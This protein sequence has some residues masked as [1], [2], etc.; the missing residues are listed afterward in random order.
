[1][2][3]LTHV[4]AVARA[5]AIRVLDYRVALDLREQPEHFASSTQVRFSARHAG[6]TWIDVRPHAVHAARLDD[7]ELDVAT[8]F[9]ASA[10]RLTL[11]AG[12]G[13]HELVVESLMAYSSD[14]EGLHRHVD[15]ADGRVYLYAMSFL[16]AA[17]R[18]FACF[19]QPDLKAPV[20]L[21]VRCPADWRVA[22]NGPATEVA[23]GHWQTAATG[24]LATYFTTVIAGPYHSVRDVHDGTELVLHVRQSLA[25]HLDRQADDLLAHTRHC[26]DELNGL[27]G[28][29]YPWGEYHQAFVPDFNAGAMENP[30][31]V[32]LR[33]QLIFRSR[34]T[35]AELADRAVTIAHE[36][37]HMWFGDLVTMRW[38]DDLWLNES[39]AEYLGHRVCGE[40]TW[41]SFGIARKSWGF[42]ADRRPSTHPV[43]GNAAADTEQ[44]LAAFDGISYAK[45]A[46]VLRQ[47]AARLGDELF[48]TGLRD[49]VG[50]HADSNA[51]FAD[52]IAAWNAAGAG[53]LDAWAQDWLRTSGLDTL[54]VDGDEILRSS[55]D[56]SRRPHA[57]SCARYDAAGTELERADVLVDADRVPLP[58]DAA[59]GLVLL[60][61]DDRT[62]AKI[63]VDEWSVLT[64]IADPS[65]R[66]VVWNALQ[67]AVADSDVDPA[68]AVDLVCSAIA[69]EPD[70][71]LAR[72]GRWAV[73]T[74][75]TCLA[76]AA[77]PDAVARLHDSFLAIVL[78]AE[79]ASA[80]QLAAFRLTVAVETSIEV[81]HGWLG[82]GAP[83]GIDVD[84][85]L[86][87]ALLS[88]SAVLGA[89]SEAQLQAAQTADPTSAGATRAAYCRAATPTVE[90]KARAWQ[91]L[92]ADPSVS[93]YELYALAEGFWHPSQ[94]ELTDPY[95]T[96]YFH[97]ILPAAALRS[98]FVVERLTAMLYPWSAVAPDTW[99]ATQQLLARDDIPA[100]A[101]RSIVD[102][103]DDLRRALQSRV[104]FS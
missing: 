41:P 16:D 70:A 65:A 80:R 78:S 27:F 51:S 15:P 54:A 103:G 67:L 21:D 99:A 77:H 13:E 25:E 96:R 83:D 4:D 34:A 6:A 32:T 29:R 89:L 14:G 102:A 86:R 93:N 61:P 49:Y 57:I 90:A 45:G 11:Q 82:D 100:G 87:W 104:R 97:D 92:T 88:R 66:V 62:W 22:A 72:V 23:P 71:V 69:V 84:D 55:G 35:D 56:G 12:V 79:P 1:M 46:S 2:A 58:F 26:L 76:P 91:R 47:L 59:D 63:V 53:D 33:D 7:V 50:A 36:M 24:P 42:A 9:D 48:L 85:D 40:Q 5:Q 52:L 101:R 44:A 94:S 3:A 74:A 30:G 73:R 98:G 68:D 19:D 64:G 81:L 18:W 43:A 39:F 8:C 38:W 37:A 28:V 10:G 95:V 60:D 31:C 75:A 20:T 17:P